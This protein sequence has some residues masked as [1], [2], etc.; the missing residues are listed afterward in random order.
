MRGPRRSTDTGGAPVSGTLEPGQRALLQELLG[1]AV[2][3]EDE[4]AVAQAYNDYRLGFD[5]LRDT[6]EHV[7]DDLEGRNT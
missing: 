5:W 3:A 7:L 6:F 1:S 4:T 2:A